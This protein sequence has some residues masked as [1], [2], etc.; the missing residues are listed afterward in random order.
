MNNFALLA[1]STIASLAVSLLVACGGDK[2]KP[3]VAEQPATPAPT[4][5]VIRVGV[6]NQYPPYD[7][8]DEMGNPIGFDVE[9]IQAIANHQKLNIELVPQGWEMLMGDLNSGKN[10]LVMSGLMRT[11]ARESKYSLSNTYAWGQDSIAIRPEN[12]SV[13]NLQD[14]TGQK[15]STLKGSAY[16]EQLEAV[17]G[18]DS[19]NIVG[20]PTD[21]LA[22]QE[23]A[24]GRVEA[25]LGEKHM[26]QHYAKNYPE[27]KFKTVDD[28]IEPYEM[29]IVAPKANADLMNKVNA[30]L[31]GIVADG[32]Y[33][34]IYQKWFGIPPAKLPSV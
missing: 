17:F 19:P 29:V 13:R 26:F 21:F 18:E 9:I 22:F 14:L 12:N 27:V 4:E 28:W 11:E 8:L 5:E 16:V 20:K 15:I 2:A 10:D 25:M 23:L 31:A 1:K 34:Q 33:A 24:L 30:G 32:T 3:K 6:D 7:F